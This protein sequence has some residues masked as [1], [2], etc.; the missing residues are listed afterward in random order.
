MLSSASYNS[1]GNRDDGGREAAEPEATQ[2]LQ[3]K[4][5]TFLLLM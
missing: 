1:Q 5:Q 3:L 4:D 2:K